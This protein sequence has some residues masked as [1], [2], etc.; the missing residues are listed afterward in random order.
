MTDR[1][2]QIAEIIAGLWPHRMSRV[3]GEGIAALISEQDIDAAHLARQRE[4]SQETFGPGDRLHGV[5]DHIRKECGEVAQ[6]SE[7]GD[8]T[9]PE[10]VDIVILAFDGAWRSGATPQQI[11]DAIKAKQARNEARTWPDW[12]LASPDHAIEH[13]RDEA[14][15]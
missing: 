10:W 14:A 7:Q 5:L 11:I 3:A 12:R 15:R 13:V 2:G 8:D 9:L 4:W 6:A 1:P